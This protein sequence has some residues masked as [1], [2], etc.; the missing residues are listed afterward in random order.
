MNDA[1]LIEMF[2]DQ[3]KGRGGQ[4]VFVTHNIKDFSHTGVDE[5]KPHPDIAKFFSSKS[6]YFTKLETP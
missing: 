4:Y 3:Q 1:M 5:Q 6:H 2:G